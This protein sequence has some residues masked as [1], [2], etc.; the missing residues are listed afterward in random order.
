[1]AR[2]PTVNS[3]ALIAL[4]VERLATLVIEAT[5][6]DGAFKKI[7]AA[8]LAGTKG[9]DAVAALI[10]RRLSSLEKARSFVEWDKAKTFTA[11]LAS[12]TQSI[13][14]E[15]GAAAPR[16]A[17]D[18]LARFVATHPKVFDRIDDSWGRVQ[19]VYDD[20]VDEAVK[21]VARI[22]PGERGAL[23]A[24]IERAMT[25]ATH[26]YVTR[27]ACETAPLLDAETLAEW[28]GR[29]VATTKGLPTERTMEGL[30]THQIAEIRQSIADARG[31]LDCWIALET[32]KT[33]H[34]R[35]TMRIAERLTAAGRHAEALDWVRRPQRR[36]LA[37]LDSADI[38]DGAS[39][40][41]VPWTDP[42]RVL[43][44]A[45]ILDALDRREEAQ[46]H[47]WASFEKTLIADVLR[48]WVDR[49]GDFEEFEALDRAFAVAFAYPAHHRA[50]VFFSDW[51][52][53]DLAARLAVDR[54]GTWSGAAYDVLVPI[55]AE[56]EET[57]PLAA[58]ILYRALL[59]DI[60]DRG[61]SAAYGHG[62]RHLAA[63]DR[64]AG[65]VADWES[66][67]PH[68]PWRDALQRRHGR[69]SS[70][71]AQLDERR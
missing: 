3:E 45:R 37:F 20:A 67:E 24:I 68:T 18:R 55:A 60:L 15:L 52:R 8:A 6:R 13:V 5:E 27:L 54:A 7:V 17:F 16:L 23:V 10:D 2:K 33:E 32:A 47:R 21:L 11:D 39:P 44:E 12:L 71:W 50:L 43:L 25:D 40:R 30:S 53:F 1:M 65:R 41:P 56:L 48:A 69:K 57:H 34:M 19:S 9:P 62:A 64:I 42:N 29:L 22:A 38:A 35:D 4:G 46:A 28:D 26:G 66:V 49:L 70:F 31:D 51:K 61:R 63:L 59:D 36:S 14:A 58:T